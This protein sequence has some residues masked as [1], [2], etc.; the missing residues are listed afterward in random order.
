LEIIVLNWLLKLKSLQGY[1]HLVIGSLLGGA[2]GLLFLLSLVISYFWVIQSKLLC[3]DTISFCKNLVRSE[4]EPRLQATGATPPSTAETSQG[5]GAPYYRGEPQAATAAPEPAAQAQAPSPEP[6]G[7]AAPPPNAVGEGPEP[8]APESP[9]AQKPGT[10]RP[11][12][13]NGKKIL[14]ICFKKNKI[15]F[16]IIIIIIIIM[17]ILLLLWLF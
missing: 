1:I 14:N 12:S 17:N 11:G 3:P 8:E 15:K 2:I 13:R 16:I 4:A 6:R 5:Q 9:A 7:P 10:T